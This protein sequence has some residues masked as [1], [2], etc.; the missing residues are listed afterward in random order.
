ML[1]GEKLVGSRDKFWMVCFL[2][3]FHSVHSVLWIV[4]LFII[5]EFLVACYNPD[6]FSGEGLVVRFR[7]YCNIPGCVI[8]PDFGWFFMGWQWFHW[9]FS[10]FCANIVA[11][12]L[13]WVDTSDVELF[14]LIVKDF[15]FEIGWVCPR[16]DPG[17]LGLAPQPSPV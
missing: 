5:S 1:I 6:L 3:F 10:S 12:S 16:P 2:L 11:L 7:A 14:I 13:Y 17:C 9:C 4:G 8:A 15:A